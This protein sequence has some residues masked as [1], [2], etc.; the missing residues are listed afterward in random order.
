MLSRGNRGRAPATNEPVRLFLPGV[1]LALLCWNCLV[2]IS[3]DVPKQIRS[4][5]IDAGSSGN[6][7]CAYTFTACPSD[8]NAL[9]LAEEF[10][11]D[12]EPGLSTFVNNP[13]KVRK[14]HHTHTHIYIYI[15]LMRMYVY[16]L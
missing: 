16:G 7:I 13:Q 12:M 15:N 5:V 4:I 2:V 10:N 1:L 11:Y 14:Q 9:T 6:R 3:A 8:P